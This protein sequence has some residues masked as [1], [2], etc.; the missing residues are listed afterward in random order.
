MK[1]RIC[2]FDSESNN[3]VVNHIEENHKDKLKM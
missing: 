1:C 3:D 2:G